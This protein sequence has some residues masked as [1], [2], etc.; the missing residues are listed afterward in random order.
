MAPDEALTVITVFWGIAAVASLIIAVPQSI[1]LVQTSHRRDK[2]W[3]FR[4]MSVLLFG[5]LGVAMGRNVAVWADLAF[6]DQAYLGALA[7]R[8]PLDLILAA[9]IMLACV[10][11]ALLYVQVQREV[12]S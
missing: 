1:L 9:L 4:L 10:L 2:L 7:T 3:P 5:S 6:A 12:L 11:A 8:W